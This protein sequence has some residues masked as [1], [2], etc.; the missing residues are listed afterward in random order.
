MNLDVEPLIETENVPLAGMMDI[1]LMKL[2]AILGRPSRKDFVDLYMICQQV[3][4]QDILNQASRKYPG[5]RD[6]VSQVVKRL[7]YFNRA[8]QDEPVSLLVDIPW[9]KVKDYFSAEA[10]ALGRSWID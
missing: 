1:A 9:E 7:V 8:D 4:L 2:D 10:K 5:V 3:S 6:F